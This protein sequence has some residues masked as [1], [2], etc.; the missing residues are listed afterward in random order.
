M[1]L[2][3]APQVVRID[4]LQLGFGFRGKVCSQM[5][6]LSFTLSTPLRLSLRVCEHVIVEAS[7]LLREEG[8]FGHLDI[9]LVQL[10][11]NNPVSPLTPTLCYLSFVSSVADC[12]ALF[13]ALQISQS[14]RGSKRYLQ[15]LSVP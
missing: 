8:T 6:Q 4:T 11:R 12:V 1:T 15:R 7:C 5:R 10:M 3:F 9:N 2:L 14:F 13:K